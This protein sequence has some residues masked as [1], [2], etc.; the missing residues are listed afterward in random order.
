[1]EPETRGSSPSTLQVDL[2][3]R[4]FILFLAVVI[5]MS[6]SLATVLSEET[7]AVDDGDTYYCYG[8]SPTLHYD[9]DITGRDIGWT[10]AYYS[11]GSVLNTE[12]FDTQSITLD[13]S[14][15]DSVTVI[16]RITDSNSGEY[17][18]MTVYLEPLHLLESGESFDIVFM[19]GSRVYDTQ[20]I[21]NHT[22]VEEG[23]DH[24]FMPA[25]PDKDGYEFGGWYDDIECTRQFNSTLPITEDKTIYARWS[26]TGETDPDDPVDTGSHLV[27]FDVDSGLEYRIL[28][29]NE[30]DISFQVGVVGGFT[31]DGD[32]QV[33]SSVGTVTG[34]NTV[35]TVSG[36]D[37]DAIITISGDTRVSSGGSSIIHVSNSVVT[38]DTDVGLEYRILSNSGRTITFEVHVTDGFRLNGDESV[39]SNRG[40][41]SYSDGIYTLSGIYNNTT[42]IITGDT[43]YVAG[44]SESSS[45]S[46][47]DFPWLYVIIA[48]I[49]VVVLIIVAYYYHRTQ[50]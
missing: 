16:Q 23:S 7:D 48:L 12:T 18:E 38:F 30:G 26:S 41:I 21:T 37:G 20:T 33:S 1:M 29:I 22:V 39:T 4:D 34:S 44:G 47:S 19:D 49:V 17:V 3:R 27:V 5:T 14:G 28:G 10:V 31:L 43:E 13:V 50:N 45:D 46:G 40:T 15:C 32:I 36:I 42:V 25:D 6:V 35:Y 24:V 8:D 2:M 11:D 9:L